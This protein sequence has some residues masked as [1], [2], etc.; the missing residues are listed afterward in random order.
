MSHKI[1]L[2]IWNNRGLNRR[3]YLSVFT[4]RSISVSALSAGL[5]STRTNGPCNSFISSYVDTSRFFFFLRNTETNY[6][7]R[8]RLSVSDR[9]LLVVVRA[10]FLWSDIDYATMHSKSPKLVMLDIV[11]RGL[12]LS[13]DTVRC[14]RKKRSSL[15]FLSRETKPRP[16]WYKSDR[17][18][19]LGGKD[20]CRKENIH[21]N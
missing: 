10:I 17:T 18:I 15:A 16:E 8:V 14:V 11:H 19:S 2:V 21:D 3:V 12:S 13:S 5:K 9:N 1:W 4:Y 6:R 7:S 20:A